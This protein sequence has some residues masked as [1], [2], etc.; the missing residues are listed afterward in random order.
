MKSIGDLAFYNCVSLTDVKLNEGLA[1]IGIGAFSRCSSLESI[2]VP[3]S[4]RI[5]RS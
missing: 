1:E 2:V 4:V 5:V 3:A